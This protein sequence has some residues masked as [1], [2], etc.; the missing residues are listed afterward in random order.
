M[1][2]R[3]MFIAVA[4][5]VSLQKIWLKAATVS[6]DIWMIFTPCHPLFLAW[7]CQFSEE[8]YPIREASEHPFYP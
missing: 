4:Q 2:N 1:S 7:V 5:I 3:V 6:K 8:Y